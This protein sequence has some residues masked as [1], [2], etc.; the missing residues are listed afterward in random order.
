MHGVMKNIAH[1]CSKTRSATWDADGWKKVVVCIIADGRE[2]CDPGVLDVLAAM[3]VYQKGVAKNMV[4][5]KPVKAHLYEVYLN[6]LYPSIV[7]YGERLHTTVQYTTQISVDAD[8]KIKGADKG[9]V[10]AQILFCLKEQNAKKINSHRWFFN[11]F[12]PVLQPN[13]CV[14]I[15]VGTRPG[16][17]SIYH[18]WKTFDL[19]ASVA[20]TCG[21]IK[22][23]KKKGNPAIA[24]ISLAPLD[25]QQTLFKAALHC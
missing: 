19:N 4:N 11:A 15:D 10:P 23:Q 5:D 6:S 20:G 12:G 18:L 17:T 24:I 13:V 25:Q 7:M 21:E 22:V 1:L 14:L 2:K 9:I 3:G 16:N 8:M